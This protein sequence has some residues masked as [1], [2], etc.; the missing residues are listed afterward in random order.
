MKIFIKMLIRTLT[1]F[2]VPPARITARACETIS[3]K[4]ILGLSRIYLRLDVDRLDWS[5]L[6][7]IRPSK[8]GELSCLINCLIAISGDFIWGWLE[9]TG[10]LL[11]QSTFRTLF[12]FSGS[13]VFSFVFSF[14]ATL[15][16]FSLKPISFSGYL[17]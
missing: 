7:R 8:N 4:Q 13:F 3:S 16:Y 6:R 10:S 2:I 17:K 1:G 14:L 11:W 15:E 5:M 9:V 12:L